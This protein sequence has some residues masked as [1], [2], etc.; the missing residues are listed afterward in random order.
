MY[1]RMFVDNQWNH[2]ARGWGEGFFYYRTKSRMQLNQPA[3]RGQDK[4]SGPRKWGLAERLTKTDRET[5]NVRQSANEVQT[6]HRIRGQ[7]QWSARCCSRDRSPSRPL[8]VGSSPPRRFGIGEKEYRGAISR[9]NHLAGWICIIQRTALRRGA[10]ANRPRRN[11]YRR[12]RAPGSGPVIA[13]LAPRVRGHIP[14]RARGRAPR[15]PPLVVGE[16][17]FRYRLLRRSRVPDAE[18]RNV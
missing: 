13:G 9:C 18:R 7:R 16:R 1:T 3:R 10:R 5:R 8:P 12:T 2:D 6:R 11:R 15:N 14:D 4:F 17:L